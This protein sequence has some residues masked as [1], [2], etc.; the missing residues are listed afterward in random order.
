MGSWSPG[1][2]TTFVLNLSAAL[3]ILAA[4]AGVMHL[5]QGAARPAPAA[6][7]LLLVA[8]EDERLAA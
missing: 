5:A 4:L 2:M 3:F 8:P 6:E 1:G 7:D